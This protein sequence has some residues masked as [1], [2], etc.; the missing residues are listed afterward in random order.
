MGPVTDGQG[1]Y[2]GHGRVVLRYLSP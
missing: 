2:G 1:G